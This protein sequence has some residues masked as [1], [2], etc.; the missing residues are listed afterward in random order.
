MSITKKLGLSGQKAIDFAQ[1]QVNNLEKLERQW[2]AKAG[3]SRCGACARK[4]D[5]FRAQL[6][7]AR[8]KLDRMVNPPTV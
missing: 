8:Q 7:T 4:R 6:R 3:R 1:N 2:A 5:K